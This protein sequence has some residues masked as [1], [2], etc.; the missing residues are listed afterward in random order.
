MNKINRLFLVFTAIF[1]ATFMS[2]CAR[3]LSSSSYDGRTVGARVSA[4]DGVIIDIRTVRVNEGDKLEDHSH[5]GA[6]GAI[7]G[8]L[9]GSAF[10]QG[11]GR[12]AMAALGAVTGAVGGAY[13]HKALTGQDAFEYT[14]KLDDGQ[15]MVVVQGRDNPLS[16]NQRVRVFVPHSDVGRTRVVA[17]R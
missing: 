10:G 16:L 12:T 9:L 11:H 1:S 14:I 7:G 8:G 13:A 4:Y 6:L 17:I 3:D 5:G 2:G 15:M